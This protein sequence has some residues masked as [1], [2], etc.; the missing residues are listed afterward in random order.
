MLQEGPLFGLYLMLLKEVPKMKW[1]S[2]KIFHFLDEM[3]RV[4]S[5]SFH[6]L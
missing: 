5:S 3:S 6:R 4:L 1:I 2:W